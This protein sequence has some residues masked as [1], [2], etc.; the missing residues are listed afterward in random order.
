VRG[1]TGSI[2]NDI[3][4]IWEVDGVIL[5]QVPE[6]DVTDI[7]DIRVLKSIASLTKYGTQGAGGVIVIQTKSGDFSSSAK[8]ENKGFKEQYANSNYY[9]NDAKA[10]DDGLLASAAVQE[11]RDQLLTQ[12]N[13]EI[14]KSLA[15]QFQA[16]GMKRDAVEAYEKVFTLRP[17]Y[18]QSYRDLANAYAENEQ[19][20]RAWRMYMSYLGQGFNGS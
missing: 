7:K 9:S 3:P 19:F 18:A 8:A 12:Q 20:K 14:I 6:L 11:L 5:G 16:M 13:P 10:A 17:K 15:Y 1:G 4:P 2:L